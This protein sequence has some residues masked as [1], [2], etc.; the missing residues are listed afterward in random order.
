MNPVKTD[1]NDAQMQGN[2]DISLSDLARRIDHVDD[3]AHEIT[4]KL[5]GL[6]AELEKHRPLLDRVSALYSGPVAGVLAGRRRR[7]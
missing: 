2:E 5:D 3:M 7:G 1:C 4:R 6:T